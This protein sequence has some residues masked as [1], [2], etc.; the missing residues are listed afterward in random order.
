MLLILI[1]EVARQW[2]KEV[3]EFLLKRDGEE[4]D[5][6]DGWVTNFLKRWKISRVCRTNV[7]K[8][9]FHE[10]LPR[11]QQFHRKLIYEVQ[12]SMPRRC[13]KYG[14]FPPARIFSMDQS[15][16]EVNFDPKHTYNPKGKVAELA[17]G[18]ELSMR[19]CTLQLWINPL[20]SQMQ[21]LPLE[22]IFF[23]TGKRTSRNAAELD[24][25]DTMPNI[26]VRWQKNAWCD[27]VV[28]VRSLAAF[29]EA[30]I[31]DGE[32]L[33]IMDRHGPQRTL[34]CKAFMRAMHIFTMY[35][36]S[37]C[38]DRV[39]PIDH[40]VA[41]TLKTKMRKILKSRFTLDELLELTAE[42]RR[43]ATARAASEAWRH[44]ISH[45]H[46]LFY[47]AF[48]ETGC[49]VAMDGSENCKIILERDGGGKYTF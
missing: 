17:I 32:V 38:T 33:L 41:Q 19:I 13:L 1:K 44:M 12:R 21:K 48:V 8:L 27:E 34:Y 42:E 25:Y 11:I 31:D 15:P 49:M 20:S 37:L 45:N 39:A 28:F 2:F 29:R 14:R 36:P 26:T 16:M 6:S 7:H 43:M 22:I 24:F 40:H 47:S 35:T 10:R 18:K 46:Q 3:M 23:G 9:S 30:T 5:L 4:R